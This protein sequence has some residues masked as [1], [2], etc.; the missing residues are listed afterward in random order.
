[1]GKYK[2]FCYWINYDII[3]PQHCQV[4]KMWYYCLDLHV[5]PTGG[6]LLI[7]ILRPRQNGRY[8]PV[9]IFK[10]IFIEI[11]LKFIPERSID[12]IPVLIQIMAWG[13]LG[14]NHYLN[15]WWLILVYIFA[16]LGLNELSIHEREAYRTLMTNRQI[17]RLKDSPWLNQMGCRSRIRSHIIFQR[18]YWCTK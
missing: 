11:S 4:S 17:R 6:G 14:D 10:C 1:M 3:L 16:S 13:R 5:V 12:T 7:A 8:Y 18:Y 9:H 15:Q 2:W